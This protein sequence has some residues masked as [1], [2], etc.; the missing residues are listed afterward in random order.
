ML[1]IENLP[2]NA[3]LDPAAMSKVA[4]GLDLPQKMLVFEDKDDAR[5]QDYA[6]GKYLVFDVDYIP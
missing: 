5:S 6:F 4:G 1:T 2:T 3:E